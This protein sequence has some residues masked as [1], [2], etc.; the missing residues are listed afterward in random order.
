MS[1][2]YRNYTLNAAHDDPWA[3]TEIQ[4]LKDIIDKLPVKFTTLVGSEHRHS[5]LVGGGGPDGS[6]TAINCSPLSV[7]EIDLTAKTLVMTGTAPQINLADNA[8]ATGVI[9]QNG[10]SL[11]LSPA[12]ASTNTISMNPA[13]VVISTD[14]KITGPQ[15]SLD[16]GGATQGVILQSNQVMTI[17]CATTILTVD[18]D[19]GKIAATATNG[20]VTGKIST[21]NSNFWQLGPASGSAPTPDTAV[22][23][24]IG[25][26]Y[27]KLAA[28]T[29]V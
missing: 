23:I 24:Q 2:T 8:V 3:P 22:L 12:A 26:T 15:I 20:F 21:D 17:T 14:T 1:T 18:G 10:P 16:G 5:L 11:T 25:A 4:V 27:Y 6:G 28:E 9:A 7:G 29:V 13:G 19:A